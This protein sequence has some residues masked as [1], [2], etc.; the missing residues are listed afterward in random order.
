MWQKSALPCNPKLS[1]NPKLSQCHRMYDNEH[2]LIYSMN[3][4]FRYWRARTHPHSKKYPETVKN[5]CIH[6]SCSTKTLNHSPWGRVTNSSDCN[7]VTITQENA[8]SSSTEAERLAEIRR[9]KAM[10]NDLVF[11]SAPDFKRPTQR[12]LE[13]KDEESKNLIRKLWCMVIPSLAM[14]FP[15]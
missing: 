11:T 6:G 3:C 15:K 13:E 14:P 4:I 7:D 5:I 9:N 8:A 1:H 12:S 2:I 10:R